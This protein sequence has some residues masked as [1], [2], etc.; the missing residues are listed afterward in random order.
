M[1][2]RLILVSNRSKSFRISHD[3]NTFVWKQLSTKLLYCV[4]DEAN[5][6]ED[7]AKGEI[8]ADLGRDKNRS[9]P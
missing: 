7:Q 3:F 2:K 8:R 9:N 6:C 5:Y 1:L 4:Q